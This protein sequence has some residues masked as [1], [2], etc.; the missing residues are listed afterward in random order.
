MKEKEVIIRLDVLL[1]KHKMSLTE[2]SQ[3]IDIPINNI[4]IFKNG[5]GSVLRIGTLLRLCEVFDCTPNDIFEVKDK[6]P[7]D[8]SPIVWREQ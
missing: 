2:L 5:R 8:P 6:N 7:D 1:A 3:K 4:S